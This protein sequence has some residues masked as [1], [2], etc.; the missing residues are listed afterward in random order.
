MLL[1][2]ISM[3]V[4]FSAGFHAAD[5]FSS[6]EKFQVIREE[7]GIQLAERWIEK[8]GSGDFR[9]VRVI[10][11]IDATAKAILS[12]LRNEEKGKL[13]NANA[14]RFRTQEVS[15]D[16]WISYSEYPLPFPLANRYCY[17]MHSAETVNGKTT[18]QFETHES[19]LFTEGKKLEPLKG[20]SG[21]WVIE[22]KGRYAILSYHII[23]V[24]DSAMPR[25]I[26][27]PIVRKNLWTNMEL[28]RATAEQS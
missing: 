18:V 21:K 1:F 5:R 26:V 8:P 12:A 27:D 22:E 24:P 23:S 9:E 15:P 4:S 16:A 3:L 13:W 6:Q 10:I 28:L 7:R 14:K 20:L 11:R 19:L 2:I 25:W 17:F